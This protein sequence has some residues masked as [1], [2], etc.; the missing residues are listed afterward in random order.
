MRKNE[1]N[2][3]QFL[4][5]GYYYKVLDLSPN[6]KSRDIMLKVA[7]LRVQFPSLD[8]YLIDVQE[9]LIDKK[10]EYEIALRIRDKLIKQL[11]NKISYGDLNELMMIA[12]TSSKAILEKP[13]IPWREIIE[14]VTAKLLNRANVWWKD[15]I[16]DRAIEILEKTLKFN[17]KNLQCKNTLLNFYNNEVT[18]LHK[19]LPSLQRGM[20][21][22]QAMM[23]LNRAD[24]LL[25]KAL[26]Y[27]PNNDTLQKNI[28]VINQEKRLLKNELRKYRK[29]AVP[30]R[31]QLM[32]SR[33]AVDSAIK[34]KEWDT[35]ITK[36]RQALKLVP[37]KEKSKI[38]ENLAYCLN[39]KVIEKLN[40]TQEEI[41]QLQK[42]VEQPQIPI[43]DAYKKI[44]QLR[45][46]YKYLDEVKEML[47]LDGINGYH[48]LNT[49]KN[50]QMKIDY[51][52]EELIPS[53]LTELCEARKLDPKN[54]TIQEN[55]SRVKKMM[56][57][58]AVKAHRLSYSFGKILSIIMEILAMFGVAIGILFFWIH[59]VLGILFVVF[60]VIYTIWFLVKGRFL[61]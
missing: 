15:G 56:G 6:S 31:K 30:Q 28:K 1:A 11:I 8:G 4:E 54:K 26:R 57:S 34:S 52:Y 10:K 13:L 41:T 5:Q 60:A 17:S 22:E 43:G 44:I 35:A 21:Y 49:A 32:N 2:L 19:Q 51:F 12:W 37:S 61:F 9:V 16:Y 53:T 48:Y 39:Q 27:Q 47:Q 20:C 42:E 7:K 29:L 38:K 45:G 40:K 14:D 55:I 46:T 24:E 59:P 50:Y 23:N 58:K 33:S 3:K 18:K 25:K 36:L